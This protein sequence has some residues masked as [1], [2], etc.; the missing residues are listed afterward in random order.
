M[1]T[2]PP[3]APAP[4][5]PPRWARRAAALTVLTTVPSGLWRTAMALGVPV[6]VDGDYWR[7]HYGFPGWGTAYVFGL[8]LLLVS[9]AALTLGLVRRWGELTP[10]WI[11]YVG[12]KHV[13]R[14][15]AMIPAGAGAVA[16]TLLWAIA[17]ANLGDIFVVYG[18]EGVERIVVIACY[19]PL[20]LW[21]PLLAAVTVSYAQRTH[22][23]RPAHD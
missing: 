21:G 2:A 23:H 13:P 18:L 4:T 1:T 3:P 22:P 6:G 10:G 7:A 12:G 15:A 9:L 17:I 16:L 20:L 8:T 11:P 19:M 5:A 14:L